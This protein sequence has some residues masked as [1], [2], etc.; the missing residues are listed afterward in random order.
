MCNVLCESPD[1]VALP[2][3]HLL[4]L[5]LNLPLGGG[6]HPPPSRLDVSCHRPGF[7]SQLAPPGLDSVPSLSLSDLLHCYFLTLAPVALRGPTLL[8]GSEGQGRLLWLWYSAAIVKSLLH[9]ILCHPSR[10]KQAVHFGS[11]PGMPS[12][13]LGDWADKKSETFPGFI[14]G[15][16]TAK[17]E[18][19]YSTGWNLLKSLL[20]CL[21][22]LSSWGSGR[23]SFIFWFL[24]SH[25][26]RVVLGINT[27]ALW[28]CTCVNA[29]WILTG[30]PTCSGIRKGLRQKAREA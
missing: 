10:Q 8:R 20:K 2:V 21:S 17:G 24:S 27:P 14:T 30:V 3:T 23:E 15:L 18:N 7:W 28:D 9:L 5:T 25:R 22:E 29:Q 11:V 26:P 4:A 16:L 1:S 13:G 6:V 12:L 19:W